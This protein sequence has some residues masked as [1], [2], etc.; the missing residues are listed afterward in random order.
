MYISLY[1]YTLHKQ[2]KPLHYKTIFRTLMKWKGLCFISLGFPL[3]RHLHLPLI[4]IP[5]ALSL[6]LSVVQCFK[7]ILGGKQGSEACI[8]IGINSYFFLV[9]PQKAHVRV[10]AIF[11]YFKEVLFLFILSS[12]FAYS[13]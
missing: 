1:I 10:I 12:I 4:T 7:I 3:F 2:G 13:L 6:P 11:V 9:A 5:M 8:C